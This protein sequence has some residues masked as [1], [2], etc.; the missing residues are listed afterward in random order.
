[1]EGI[2]KFYYFKT[3]AVPEVKKKI[4]ESK[5]SSKMGAGLEN[6]QQ[7]KTVQQECL[8]FYKE[9]VKWIS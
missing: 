6:D 8:K 2:R 5:N 1:M 7:A 9:K 4:L 3:H